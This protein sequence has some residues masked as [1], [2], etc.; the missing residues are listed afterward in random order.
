MRSRLPPYAKP[1]AEARAKGL[2]PRR[3]GMGQVCVVLS[4]DS[5]A[6]A[7]LHRVVLPPDLA[8]ENVDFGWLAGLAV[9]LTHTDGEASRVPA[10]LDAILANSAARVDVIN[11]DQVRRGAPLLDAWARF[12]PEALRHAA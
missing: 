4:W 7:G 8:P 3:M 1:L 10:V 6:T 9:L 11:L 12:E 2:M 5:H